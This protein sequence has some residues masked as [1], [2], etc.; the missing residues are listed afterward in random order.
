VLVIILKYMIFQDQNNPPNVLQKVFAI[1]V[2]CLGLSSCVQKSDIEKLQTK[3]ID[4]W[5]YLSNTS[6]DGGTISTSTNVLKADDSG[7][8]VALTFECNSNSSLNLLMETFV[9]DSAQ[10]API[11]MRYAKSAFGRFKVADIKVLNHQSSFTFVTQEST[12]SNA[13]VLHLHPGEPK[14][15]KALISASLKLFVPLT[16]TSRQLTIQLD[17]PNIQKVFIDCA[18]KPAF[19][20][21][22]KY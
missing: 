5:T 1:L 7:I 19:M 13:I 11:K 2:I 6:T 20:M 14:I 22:G 9:G 12:H 15:S 16:N 17:N 10:G 4:G 3:S 18:Y 8:S 21:T